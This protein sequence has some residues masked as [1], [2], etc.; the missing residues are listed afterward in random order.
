[1]G[2]PEYGLLVENAN[3]AI[4]LAIKR[5]GYGGIVHPIFL[6]ITDANEG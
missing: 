6:A 4:G 3:L 2:E 5:N 1:M